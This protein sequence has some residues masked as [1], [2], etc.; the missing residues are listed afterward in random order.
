MANPIQF[1]N[2]RGGVNETDP[3]SALPEDQVV[4]A[5]NVEYRRSTCGEKR[6]GTTNV[7]LAALSA[8]LTIVPFGYRHLPSADATAAEL[9]VLYTP[10]DG[11]QAFAIHRK[12][13]AWSAITPA[14]DVDVTVGRNYRLSAASLHGRMFLAYRSVGG[15]DRLHCWD[16]TSLRRVGLATPSAAPAVADTG[17]AATYTGVRY[18][19][20]R[21]AVLSGSTVLRRSEFSATTTF[22]PSGAG[23]SAR[24]TKPA[25]TSPAEGETHWEIEESINNADFYRI[26]TVA[27]GTTTY[28]DSIAA[29]TTG[30]KGAGGV[31]SEDA[32]DYTVPWSPKY[33]TTDQDRLI[34]AGSWENSAYA[35]R[36]G[37][38]PVTL[39]PGVGNDERI[40]LDTNN[41]VDLDGLDGGELTGISSAI[42]GYLFAFKLGRVYKGTRTG[43]RDKAYDWI[44]IT[45]ERG[46]V[47]GSVKNG[48]DAQG[49]AC[50]YFLDPT[51]GLCRIGAGGLQHA[52]QDV[53][54]TWRTFNKDATLPCHGL[55][56]PDAHQLRYWIATS[57]SL[58][59]NKMLVLHTNLSRDFADGVRKGWATWSEGASVSAYSSWLFSDNID[60]NTTRSL[61]I[62]PFVGLGEVG[63]DRN[64]IQRC[65][66]GS[67]D[68]GASYTAYVRTRPIFSGGLLQ[69]F[70]TLVGVVLAK[71]ASGVSMAVKTIRDFGLETKTSEA[72]SLTPVGT[73]DQVIRPIDNLTQS[74]MF[75][76]QVEFGDLLSDGGLWEVNS[77]AV[78]PREEENLAGEV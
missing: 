61:S 59:P 5:E 20:V 69:K 25:A 17:G 7:T 42:N 23:T 1:T 46:A 63:G 66:T 31:L 16:G 71:A 51:V 67:T 24:I 47:P 13:T 37:W 73:E 50:I 19:R 27:V 57:G 53:L 35:S 14:D 33:L 9:W 2:L 60:A 44:C 30:L 74:E 78:M 55:Y 76:L 38:T 6:R 65:D 34:I 11:T 68:R 3:P 41:S 56:Y 70:G 52:G 28:D 39:D 8:T 43:Q 36:V 29:Y 12:T 75:A 40:P 15:V 72:V 26:A 22:T 10:S 45:S 54:T 18:F 58:F 32:G 48:F 4:I 77:I 49:N 64:L 21:Y 62:V